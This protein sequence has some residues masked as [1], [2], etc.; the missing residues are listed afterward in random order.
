MY[1][2][3]GSA[4]RILSDAI[5]STVRLDTDIQILD[6]H[7]GYATVA[8]FRSASPSDAPSTVIA[9]RPGNWAPFDPDSTTGTAWGFFN[10]WAALE[11][12]AGSGIAPRFFGGDRTAPLLLLE[13]LGDGDGLADSLLGSDPANANTDLIEFARAL[14]RMHAFSA[15]KIH[16]YERIRE[17]LGPMRESDPPREL[18]RVLSGFRTACATVGVAV[19]PPAETELESAIA[20][21]DAH[22]FRAYAHGDPCPDNTR[23]V[24]GSVRLF[25]FEV[26]RVRHPLLD[27]SYARV[28]FPTCWCVQR[29]PGEVIDDME[30]AYRVEIGRALPSLAE[31]SVFREHLMAAHALWTAEVSIWHVPRAVERDEDLHRGIHSR[32]QGVF[33]R[34]ETFLHAAERSGHFSALADL[35][36]ELVARLRTIWSDTPDVPLYPAFR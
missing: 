15:P 32:R 20:L 35:G 12:L 36:R 9:K 7:D 25:D 21:M 10:E 11:F 27:G 3:R 4:E 28:P 17:R 18:E 30:H 2:L 29:L 23:I 5:G 22:E 31:G 19:S 8:R 33:L 16:E 13:D 6:E 34:W 26:G 1:E 14:G 24:D